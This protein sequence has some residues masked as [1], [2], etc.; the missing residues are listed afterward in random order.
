MIYEVDAQKFNETLASELKN[1]KEFTM[2]EWAS[3][4]KTGPSKSRP[5]ADDDFWYKRAA[6]ILR[7]IHK[8]RVV[9]VNRLRTRYGG[10]QIRGM[11]PEMFRKASGKI[12]R[13]ILQ[14]AEKAG[15]LEKVKGKRT[16]RKLTDK[17]TKFLEETA[18]KLK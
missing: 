10:R 17:G 9:G 3:Y 13:V 5:P 6:S 11:K 7:Q 18:N 8:N 1:L 16:G 12:I 14:Q 4:V 2:P 15:F